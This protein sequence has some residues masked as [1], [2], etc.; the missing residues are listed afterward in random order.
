MIRQRYVV[1]GHSWFR[2]SNELDKLK[3]LLQKVSICGGWQEC[4]KFSG[5]VI[6]LGRKYGNLNSNQLKK[7][8][9]PRCWNIFLARMKKADFLLKKVMLHKVGSGNRETLQWVMQC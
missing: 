1:S 2:V 7:F 5:K 3:R 4:S 8:E 6:S 9:E